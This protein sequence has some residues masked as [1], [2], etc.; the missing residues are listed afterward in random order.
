MKRHTT[1]TKTGFSRLCHGSSTVSK[2]TYE[3]FDAPTSLTV[4]SISTQEMCQ[5]HARSDARLDA[6]CAAVCAALSDTVCCD[7]YG[8]LLNLENLCFW[9]WCIS[10]CSVADLVRKITNPNRTRGAN[11]PKWQTPTAPVMPMPQDDRPRPHPW[12]QI[13]SDESPCHRHSKISSDGIF[14]IDNT[15][16]SHLVSNS[17][18]LSSWWVTESKS[19][20]SHTATWEPISRK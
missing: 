3:T 1:Q 11:A 6:V 9:C 19:A 13:P 20:K 16:S 5:Q 10:F 18:M 4:G 8:V 12:R 15:T 14:N 2:V 17:W 7:I